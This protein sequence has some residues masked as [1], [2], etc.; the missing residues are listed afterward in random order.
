MLSQIFIIKSLLKMIMNYEFYDLF[1]FRI[2]VVHQ[3][4]MNL[5]VHVVRSSAIYFMILKEASNYLNGINS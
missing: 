5:Q 1:L 3:C 2:H 4:Y